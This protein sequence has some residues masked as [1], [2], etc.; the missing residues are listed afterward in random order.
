MT[1]DLHKYT[2]NGK[3]EYILIETVDNSFTVQGRMVETTNSFGNPISTATVFS[4]IAIKQNESD[5]VQFELFYQQLIVLVNGERIDFDDVLTEQMFNNVT[6]SKQGN[7][8]LTATF[9]RGENIK[10]VEQNG[11][12]SVM[13]V[14]LPKSYIGK[15]RGLMGSN[16]GNA[17]NDLVPRHKDILL[18]LNSTIE[19]IHTNFGVS[20]MLYE[21]IRSNIKLFLSYFLH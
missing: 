12:L 16:D 3:G 9:S 15:T 2:F 10:L 11:I 6:I 18:P 8:T 5:T 4:A 19:S 1:L 13:L 7:N 17:T 21:N 14:S 20:C